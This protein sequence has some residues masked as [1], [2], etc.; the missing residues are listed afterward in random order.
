MGCWSGLGGAGGDGEEVG[1]GGLRQG[2]ELRRV[3]V[4]KGLHEVGGET[5][6]DLGGHHLAVALGNL[7]GAVDAADKVA[8]HVVAHAVEFGR[9]DGFAAQ[10]FDFAVDF[11]HGVGGGFGGHIGG[12]V[13]GYAV[14]EY[15]GLAVDAVGVAFVLAEVGHE[16]GAEVAAEDGVEDHETG[17]VGAV[18]GEGEE[19]ADADGG[20][21]GAGQ[22]GVGMG[23]GGLGES[24]HG[25]RDGC[26]ALGLWGEVG[27]GQAEQCVVDGSAEDEVGVG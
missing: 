16:A 9:A 8:H 13:E 1:E 19:A 27:V 12:D 14:A 3:D 25:Q 17:V 5:L 2:E 26:G 18:P 20:L 15:L 11:G 24:G 10:E 22:W 6:V 23:C 21:H 7:E 4:G